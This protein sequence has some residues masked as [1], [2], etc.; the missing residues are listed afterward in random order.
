MMKR[1]GEKKDYAPPFEAT[2]LSLL[3]LESTTMAKL[4]QDTS[5]T[6]TTTTTHL[7]SQTQRL[8]EK[9]Q[10]SCGKI[11]CIDRS[12]NPIEIISQYLH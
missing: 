6:T 10:Q 2:T 4:L 8:E 5:A 9:L 3:P 7:S 11:V 12:K 1:E